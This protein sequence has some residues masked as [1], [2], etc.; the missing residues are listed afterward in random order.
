MYSQII[1]ID[2]PDKTGKD[3]VRD[4][5]VKQS[6]G[7]YLVVVRSYISQIVYS[8][9][10]KRKINEVF[11]WNKL[12]DEYGAGTKFFVLLCN[13]Q[14]ATERFKKHN[15]KD[16]HISDFEKH[17]NM[18]KEVCDEAALKGI[19]ITRIDTS[20]CTPND[21]VIRM[22]EK[23]HNLQVKSCYNCQLCVSKKNIKSGTNEWKAESEILVLFTQQFMNE[24]VY[25]FFNECLIKVGIFDKCIISNAVKCSTKAIIEYDDFESCMFHTKHLIDVIKPKYII[26][27]GNHMHEYLLQSRIFPTH[28]IIKIANPYSIVYGKKGIEYE[29]QKYL[30][31]LIKTVKL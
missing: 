29:Q 24:E 27:V 17:Q 7:N 14:T 16:L 15:E 25:S 5:I 11:F 8:R 30:K 18:F 19:D 22:Q 2:G 13:I 6:E 20:N 4:I 21:V 28:K 31:N 1:H 12:K 23:I 10:Y 26:A 9:L 3:T